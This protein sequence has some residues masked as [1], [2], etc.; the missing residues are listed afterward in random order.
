MASEAVVAHSPIKLTGGILDGWIL[1]KEAKMQHFLHQR[2]TGVGQDI[3]AKR[4][5]LYEKAKAAHP[6]RWTGRTRDWT[7][8]DQVWLNPERAE[9][10]KSQEK[11]TS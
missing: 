8:D 4:Q 1:A 6:E 2:H 5:N 10:N 9:D 7:L 11:Q 3:L